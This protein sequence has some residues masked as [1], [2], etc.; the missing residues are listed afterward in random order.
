M[1]TKGCH[2]HVPVGL[3]HRVNLLNQVREQTHLFPANEGL[4]KVAIRFIE[5]ETAPVLL[6]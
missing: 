3:E 6:R 5:H 1:R 2:A 4:C